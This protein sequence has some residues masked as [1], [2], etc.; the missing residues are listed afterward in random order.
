MSQNIDRVVE[1]ILGYDMDVEVDKIGS[2]IRNMLRKDLRR[3]GL[4]IA[5][6]GGIDSSVSAALCVKAIGAKRVFGL[7]LPETDS[8]SESLSRG[9]MLSEHLGIEYIVENIAPG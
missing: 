2:R 9:K 5:I 3:R 4:V 7:L 8:S 1:D 6:S